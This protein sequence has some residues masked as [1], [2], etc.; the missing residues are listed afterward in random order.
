MRKA[1]FVVATIA[2]LA[3]LPAA[4]QKNPHA[5]T[6]PQPRESYGAYRTPTPYS[7]RMV[8]PY[9]HAPD[10]RGTVRW[11]TPNQDGNFGGPSAG[12]SSGSPGG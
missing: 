5:K 8:T 12:G 11:N 2:A 1:T 3:A 10:Y 6:S 4:A 7:P 9:A